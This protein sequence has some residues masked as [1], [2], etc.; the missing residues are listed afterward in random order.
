LPAVLIVA[1]LIWG[2][3]PPHVTALRQGEVER[4]WA[5]LYPM[6]AVSAGL[7]VD[8]CTHAGSRRGRIWAGAVVALLVLSVCPDRRGQSLSDN[9]T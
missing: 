7:V 4:T 3:L 8:R 2:A 1:M 5:F 9:L 6:L